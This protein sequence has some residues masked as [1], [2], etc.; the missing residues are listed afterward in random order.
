[1]YKRIASAEDENA[2]KELQVEMID[3]FGLLPPQVK[4]LFDIT[5]FKNQASSMGIKKIDIGTNGG[6]IVF[7]EQP[8]IDPMRVI[9]LIQ[10]K[11]SVYKLDGKDKLRITQTLD[12][13]GPRLKFVGEL[14]QHLVQQEAA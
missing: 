1:M 2:L 12:E 11:S 6:R 14:L 7:T 5:R 3:R 4:N 8:N 10:T 9:E 13:P